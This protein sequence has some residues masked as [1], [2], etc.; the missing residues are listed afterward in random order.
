MVLPRIAFAALLLFLASHAPAQPLPVTEI[1]PGN[2]VHYGSLDERSAANLGDQANIGFIVGSRCVAVIDTGGS[3][4]VGQRLLEALRAKTDLPVCWVII[5]H[6]HPDHFFG[7]AAFRGGQVVFAGHADLPRAL[8]QR[9]RFYLNTLMRDLDGAAQ[10]SE[11]VE[12]T[13]LVKDRLELDLG[14]RK[15]LLQAWPVAHTDNDLT[16]IDERTQT[17][18]TGDLLFL[19]HTPVLDGSLGGFLRVLGD[20]GRMTPAHY[21]AG[22]GRTDAS[23]ADAVA[24]ERHY[25]E[26]IDRETRRALK[27]RRTLQEA[28]ETVGTSE[29]GN[30]VNFDLYHRR[31]VTAA[32][33]ELEWED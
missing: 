18:W 26:V 9:G 22:H 5:T 30:W 4:A 28:T 19:Q 6:A 14:D 13:L 10:G 23:F 21:V 20:L 7:A 25:F 17:L 2:F 1:A 16:V 29:A 8:Q 32:Y 11:V 3:F 24:A 33:T 15:L 31:N 27:Q 12:P